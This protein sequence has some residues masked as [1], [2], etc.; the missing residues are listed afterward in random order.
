MIVP[1]P[2]I[3]SSNLPDTMDRCIGATDVVFY[4][5]TYPEL[6]KLNTNGYLIFVFSKSNWT[7][8]TRCIV[9]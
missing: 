7:A 1:R 9:N 5:A 6:Y 3:K 2:G 8:M 4:A